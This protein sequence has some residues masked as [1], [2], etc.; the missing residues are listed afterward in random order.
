MSVFLGGYDPIK[1][2]ENLL[3]QLISKEV[4]TRKEAEMVISVGKAP[5]KQDSYKIT[6]REVKN[7]N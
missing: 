3:N 7:D 4:L 1:I 2:I 6:K 5:V